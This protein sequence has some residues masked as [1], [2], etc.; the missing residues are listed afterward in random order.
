MLTG[1]VASVTDG[2][3]IVVR[4]DGGTSERLRYIGVDTPES[5][6][7]APVECFG[8][9]AAAANARVVG[10]RRVLLR[11]GAEPRD[12]YG[13]LLAYVFL[14]RRGGEAGLFVNAFLVARGY[15]RTLTI[16]PNDDRAPLFAALESAAGRRG[17]GLWSAC[18]G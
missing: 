10:G 6:P 17:R 5:V 9:R 13:R 3:T 16:A 4:L 12:D 8:R 15:A 11:V 14:A 1:R 2:D 7:G 18:A